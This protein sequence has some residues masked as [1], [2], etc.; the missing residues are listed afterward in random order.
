MAYTPL[1]VDVYTAAFAGAMSGLGV[2][3]GAFIVDPTTGDYA[4]IAAVAAVFAQAVD[5]AWGTLAAN[6]YDLAAISNVSDSVLS[7]GP[8]YPLSAPLTTQ[9]NWTTVATAIVAMVRQGDT[10]SG[11]PQNITLPGG[12]NRAHG[13]GSATTAG[14][15]TITVIAA[16]KLIAKGSGIFKAWV[17]F[18]YNLAAVDVGTLTI[19][20]YTDNVAGT[21]LTLGNAGSIGFG[22]NGVAQPGNVTV[23]NNGVF[24]ANAGAGI[25][26][27]GGSAGYVADTKDI[28]EGTAAVKAI[29][30]WEN[31]V[32]LAAPSTGV[33][34]PIVVGRT[35]LVTASVTNS[36]A[37][38]AT[39]NISMGMFEL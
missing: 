2:P 34:T 12:P 25:T 9:A 4:G 33:E 1:N 8:G 15:A 17:N 13:I 39:G 37:A 38:R 29:F 31:I 24:T 18:V 7:R 32:G 20:V 5:T 11:T 30:M 35:C 27:T 28:T 14:Q 10:Y 22:S 23:N 3:N 21:P 36:V 16:A 19:N 26:I 6:A